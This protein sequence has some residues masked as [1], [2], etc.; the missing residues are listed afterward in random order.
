MS[1]VGRDASPPGG[2][3]GGGLGGTPCSPEKVSPVLRH[4]LQPQTWPFP[5]DPP[6]LRFLF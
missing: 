1:E 6:R 5:Q 4:R 2:I 3:T